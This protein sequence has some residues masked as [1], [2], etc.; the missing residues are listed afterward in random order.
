MNRII[1]FSLLLFFFLGG[2]QAFGQPAVKINNGIIVLDDNFVVYREKNYLKTIDSLDK[3]LKNNPKDT[4]ALFYR[5]L[6]YTRSN[7]ILA[8]PYQVDPKA[9]AELTIAKTFVERALTLSMQDFKLKVLRAEI[10]AGLCYRY[11]GDESWKFKPL[12]I[13]ARKK[14]F[15]EYKTKAN[16]YYEELAKVDP[17]NAYDY[18]RRLVKYDYPIK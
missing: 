7:D 17:H 4:S 12:E 9:L 14:S 5:A 16:Q 6:F 3:V 18:E 8:K 1:K 13:T 10:F 15:I 11:S 2:I